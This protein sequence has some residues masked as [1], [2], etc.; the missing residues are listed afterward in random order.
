MFQ[1]KEVRKI[2]HFLYLAWPDYGVPADSGGFL[3]F[4]FHVRK[5]QHELTKEIEWKVGFIINMQVL[6]VE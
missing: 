6:A 5:A 4:L 2:K 1:T 3:K